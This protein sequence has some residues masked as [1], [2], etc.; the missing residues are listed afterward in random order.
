VAAGAEIIS[1]DYFGDRDQP[2]QA[3]VFA[4]GRDL[5]R[6]LTL[7]ALA[8]EARRLA[9]SVDIIMVESG[10]EN[11]TA[12]QGI[13]LSE[14]RRFNSRQAV[15]AARELRALKTIL[16]GTGL[17]LPDMILPGEPL[18]RSGRWLAKD[19]RHSGGLG[20]REWNRHQPLADGE[21]LE[22]FAPGILMSA[23]FVA[24]GKNTSLLGLSRQYAG[25][26]ELGAA[27]F[28]W[29]GNVAPWCDRG[30]QDLI[31]QAISCLVRE[32]GLVGLNGI[33]FVL[34]TGS[35]VLLEINPRPPASFELFE[36]LL[37]VNAF[38]LHLDACLGH[39]P[40]DLPLPPHRQ[41][42]GKGIVYAVRDLSVNNAAI[43]QTSDIADIPHRGET[44]PAGAPVCTL[45]TTGKD[46]HSCWQQVLG[47]AGKLASGF[48]PE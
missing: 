44:I 32:C 45:L 21:I 33:D 17:A 27:P 1:L 40:A 23:C 24:D 7:H 19:G 6:P 48:E 42:W 46:I 35:P 30:L 28:Q 26:T 41:V 16:A 11:E 43:W 47:K 15:H 31:F 12:L 25:I 36:R 20:V 13:G 34:G 38:R 8:Q 3:H 37:G 18:P 9:P 5:H 14:Q 29:C 10:L 22:R 2:Q 39:L 4:L